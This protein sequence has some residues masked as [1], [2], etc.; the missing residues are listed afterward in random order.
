MHSQSN[1]STIH[2]YYLHVAVHRYSVTDP[3]GPHRTKRLIAVHRRFP[4]GWTVMKNMIPRMKRWI[5]YTSV[6]TSTVRGQGCPGLA[7]ELR[8]ILNDVDLATFAT[9]GRKG[10]PELLDVQTESIR[11]L[12]P[13]G[14]RHWGVARKVLNIF[15][16]GATYNCFLRDRFKLQQLEPVLELPLDKWTVKALKLRSP[17]RSLPRWKAIKHLTHDDSDRFQTQA[18]EWAASKNSLRVHLDIVFWVDRD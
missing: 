7:Q 1:S 12:M 17:P 15:L 8:Q 10:F 4:A 2:C 3:Y 11:K 13:R 5:A 6:G 14:T 16:R 9:G 18:S